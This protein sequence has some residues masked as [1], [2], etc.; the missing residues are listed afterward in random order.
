MIGHGSVTRGHLAGM[1]RALVF[2]AVLVFAAVLATPS[3]EAQRRARRPTERVTLVVEVIDR[4]PTPIIPCG[5]MGAQPR[6]VTAQ[7]IAVEEGTFAGE[8]ILL[9]WPMCVL[10]QVMPGH[11]YRI[12]IR[13]WTD[14]AV[15]AETRYR[16]RH[17]D[18]LTMP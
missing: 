4:D 1:P 5:I 18:P 8:R 13:R 11:R 12:Q 16:V 9:D 2:T 7:V 10:G 14:V 15:T 17:F 3:G 6:E